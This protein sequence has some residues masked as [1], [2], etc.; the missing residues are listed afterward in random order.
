MVAVV[1]VVAAALTGLVIAA[2][3]RVGAFDCPGVV[4]TV[5]PGGYTGT[6]I[7]DCAP[8]T[9]AWWGLLLGAAAGAATAAFFIGL[10]RRRSQRGGQT[11]GAGKGR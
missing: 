7:V 9:A 5:E 4:T 1:L 10:R 8:P 6:T 3:L 2:V 11:T